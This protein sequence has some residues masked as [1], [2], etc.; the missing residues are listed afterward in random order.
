MILKYY[1]YMKYL[2][3]FLK[4]NIQGTLINFKNYYN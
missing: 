1:V 2:T 4:K 3:A